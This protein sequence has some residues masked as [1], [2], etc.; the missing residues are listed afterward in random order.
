MSFTIANATTANPANFSADLIVDDTFTHRLIS[1]VNNGIN[2]L[3]L[4]DINTREIIAET[5][6]D[7]GH[8]FSNDERW[9]WVDQILK[10]TALNI[11]AED[12][13]TTLYRAGNIEDFRA[14]SD[15]TTDDYILKINDHLWVAIGI[16]EDEDGT[17]FLDYA[18]YASDPEDEGWGEDISADGFKITDVDQAAVT[19]IDHLGL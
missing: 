16:E 2:T 5:H 10:H 3:R 11:T 8:L 17:Y 1:T 4:R 18:Q 12:I 9:A 7:K 14:S 13:A 6:S 19:L 15:I